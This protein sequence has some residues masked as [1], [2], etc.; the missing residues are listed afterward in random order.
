[1]KECDNSKMHI[2][3]MKECGNSKMHISSNFMLCL[4]SHHMRICLIMC[5]TL[6]I[7]S[8]F[9]TCMIIVLSLGCG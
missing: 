1:M 8:C 7:F 9:C 6:F 5:E 4:C 3:N 2:K